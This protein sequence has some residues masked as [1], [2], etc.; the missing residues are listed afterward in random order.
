MMDNY[1]LLENIKDKFDYFICTSN[2]DGYF[3]RS[4]FDEKIYEVHVVL[5]IYNVWIKNVIF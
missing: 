3:K 5:T 4:G 1:K 2:I